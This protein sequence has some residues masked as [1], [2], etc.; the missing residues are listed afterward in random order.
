MPRI[1]GCWSRQGLS[2]MRVCGRRLF[3]RV[4]FDSKVIN[5]PRNIPTRHTLSTR[6]ITP[7][8][9]PPSQPTLSTNPPLSTHPLNPPSQPTLSTHPLNSP[10]QPTL[11]THPLNP[12]SQPSITGHHAPLVG[13]QTVR[14]SPEIITGDP[15]PDLLQYT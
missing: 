14:D 2:M 6:Y 10:S 3:P 12:P 1:T 11:S 15:P 7:S 5:H 4:C 13:C 9:P 8:H